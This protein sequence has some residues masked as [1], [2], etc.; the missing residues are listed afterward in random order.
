MRLGQPLGLRRGP[1]TDAFYAL[2]DE[3]KWAPSHGRQVKQKEAEQ[4]ASQGWSAIRCGGSDSHH[5]AILVIRQKT[6]AI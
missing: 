1:G 3:A 2:D 6:D 4:S 5:C